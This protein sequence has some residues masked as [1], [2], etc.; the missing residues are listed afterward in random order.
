MK[1]VQIL[2]LLGILIFLGAAILIV[3]N[4]W[5][6][7]ERT[8]KVESARKLFPSFDIDVVTKIE[9]TVDSTTTILTKS[10]GQWLVE[11][12]DSYPADQ[13][14]VKDILEKA[15][16]FKKLDLI[17]KNPD[18]QA[19]FEVDS[20]GVETKFLDSGNKVLAHVFIG[21]TTSSFLDSY[22]R[23][24]GSDEVYKAKGYLK[25]TF[26]KGS[27]TWKTRKIFAFNKGDVTAL[28]MKS[29]VEEIELQLDSEG[30]WQMLK[31]VAS[32]AKKSEIDQI[33]NSLST[34]ETDDFVDGEDFES[35]SAITA[36]LNDGS[37]RILM[38]ADEDGGK[39]PAKRDGEKQIFALYK[40]NRDKLFKSSEDL[41]EEPPV[42]EAS[43]ENIEE[44]DGNQIQKSEGN[45]DTQN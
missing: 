27:R 41:K 34:L 23:K 39:H 37:Q 9:I 14:G 45:E 6:K 7:D 33:L 18:K 40:Y 42:V 3:D 12:M 10:G 19:K 28:T 15:S 43:K 21:K 30:K 1:I 32:L 20:S 13:Q 5:G 26:D 35:T 8:K 36:T 31:P 2:I 29:E 4:P 11:S 24:D 22:I 17:S 25:S 44:G 16:E 38:T